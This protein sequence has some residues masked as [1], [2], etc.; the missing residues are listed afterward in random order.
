MSAPL[1]HLTACFSLTALWGNVL[2]TLVK[3]RLRSLA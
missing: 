3:W 1:W 2:A